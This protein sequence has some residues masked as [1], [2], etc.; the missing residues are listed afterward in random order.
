MRK[1]VQKAWDE[2]FAS[3]ELADA[4]ELRAEGWRGA[5]EFQRAELQRAE[6]DPRLECRKFRVA[7]PTGIRTIRFFR[8]KVE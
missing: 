5:S 2:Y 1:D 6:R 7:T 3:R 8:P 4:E